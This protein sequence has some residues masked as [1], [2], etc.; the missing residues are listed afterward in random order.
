MFKVRKYKMYNGRSV[1]STEALLS[2]DSALI[3]AGVSNYNLVRV[4]SILP[5]NFSYCS[6]LDVLHGDVLFTAYSAITEKG[7]GVISAAIA[8]GIPSHA[9][10]VGVIM[11]HSCNDVAKV[12]ESKVRDMVVKAMRARDLDIKEILSSSVEIE[13][14]QDSYATAIS[15]IALW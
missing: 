11:E 4:S 7:A 8:V 1:G 2:F 12:S 13:L 14:V 5:P 6:E 10:N 3:E 15:G 9:S